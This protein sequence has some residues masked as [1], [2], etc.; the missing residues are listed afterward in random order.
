[1]GKRLGAETGT[2]LENGERAP[3]GA[4][5]CARW[6]VCVTAALC[7][8]PA[9]GPC[10]RAPAPVCS[11]VSGC[12][13]AFERLRVLHVHVSVSAEN[14]CVYG[15]VTLSC[16]QAGPRAERRAQH[17]GS[18]GLQVAGPRI[19][20]AVA[21][22]ASPGFKDAGTRRGPVVSRWGGG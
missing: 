13:C 12:P 16:V 4:C 22:P 15:R 14:V 1:M 6:G 19:T 17:P 10:G 21:P 5:Q 7:V 2:P 9:G 8:Q 20:E 3:V 18:A 11:C